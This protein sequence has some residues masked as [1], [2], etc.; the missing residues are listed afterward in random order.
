MSETRFR[1][2]LWFDH[3]AEEA[4]S[5][6]V[7]I[8]PRSR[9]L[10]VARYPGGGRMPEG[11]VLSAG[12]ELDGQAFVALNGGM[13]FPVTPA[14]STVVLC[15]TQDEIDTL[16]SRLSAD[17]AQEQCGW[18]ADRWGY[19]WQVVPRRLLALL[20][21]GSAMQRRQLAE[22][23]MTMKKL[24]IAALEAAHARHAPA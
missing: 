6:Y 20:Q 12:F 21:Q 11:M 15:D 14:V 9:V 19:A 17:P 8:F 7:S 16:W 18:L 10:E 24:D 3:D 22:C 23:L 4:V 5:H 13:R 2:C 1:T